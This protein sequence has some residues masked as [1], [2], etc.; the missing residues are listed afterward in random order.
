MSPISHVNPSIRILGHNNHC[1]MAVL[2]FVISALKQSVVQ[3][4]ALILEQ[5]TPVWL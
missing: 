1:F 4:V 5:Q 2:S 3:F